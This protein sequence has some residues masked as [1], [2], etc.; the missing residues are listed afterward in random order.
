MT[1]PKYLQ[2][3]DWRIINPVN[4]EVHEL[5]WVAH[6]HPETLS[7]SDLSD[8]LEMAKAYLHLAAHPSGTEMCLQKL[9]VIRRAIREGE[10]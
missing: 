4:D 10:K 5:F 6:H 7:R 8:I 3:E 1:Q 9:R 2:F